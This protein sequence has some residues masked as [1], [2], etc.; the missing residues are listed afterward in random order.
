MKSSQFSQK[1]L[2]YFLDL[3]LVSF[4]IVLDQISKRLAV[5]KL[6]DCPFVIWNN[7]FELHYL[8][9]RG[10]AFGMLQNKRV[11]LLIVAC[12]FMFVMI[13]I[14]LKLPAEKKFNWLHFTISGIIAGGIGNMID[15]FFY[16]Y[17]VDFF[18]FKLID[19][20][21]FNV[22]DIY[23]VLATIALIILFLFVYSEE[24]FNRIWQNRILGG[25]KN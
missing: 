21:I 11:F 9:N 18:Y 4:L 2:L 12:L 10:S 8:E 16:G 15:R 19:F 22:A 1:K 13:A 3:I 24:D 5:S 20:P 14:L 6:L 23:I 17:V 25:R 7:V